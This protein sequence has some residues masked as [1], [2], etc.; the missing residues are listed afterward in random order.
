MYLSQSM[1]VPHVQPER[2]GGMAADSQGGVMMHQSTLQHILSYHVR[3]IFL[4]MLH[5]QACNVPEI[6]MEQM[7]RYELQQRSEAAPP[8]PAKQR[9]WHMVSD[10]ISSYS[11]HYGLTYNIK[12]EGFGPVCWYTHCHCADVAFGCCNQ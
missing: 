5:L 4:T 11:S 7:P 2:G 1:S 10:A 9:C 12:I 3:H 8:T 6:V